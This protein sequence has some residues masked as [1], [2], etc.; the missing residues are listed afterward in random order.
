MSNPDESKISNYI[1]TKS[2]A[3]KVLMHPESIR[4]AYRAGTLPIKP[5]LF[6]GRLL[7]NENEIDAYLDA[8][9]EE[10]HC[11]KKSGR[12]TK[13]EEIE[14]RQAKNIN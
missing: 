10:P 13:Q 12:P 7:W 8:T 14:S 2:F 3:K 11:K 4:R 1:T 6:M 5:R 9:I